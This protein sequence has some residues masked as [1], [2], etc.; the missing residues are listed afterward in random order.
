MIKTG[1]SKLFFFNL[2]TD[3]DS[4][5]LAS[6][7]SW[8]SEFSKHFEE[9][10]VV[11]THIGRT[12]LPGNVRLVSLGGGSALS[13]CIAILKLQK[14]LISIIRIKDTSCVFYHMSAYSAFV[15]GPAIK[16]FKIPQIM[17]YSH[18]KANLISKLAMFWVSK[19]YSTTPNSSPYKSKKLRTGQHGIDPTNFQNF[20]KIQHRKRIISSVGRIVPIKN[21]EKLIESTAGIE[22]LSLIFVGPAPNF[23]YKNFLLNL[24]NESDVDLAILPPVPYEEI[25][26]IY[27]KTSIYYTGTPESI[28]KAAIE[29]AMSGCF[30][31]SNNS[32]L[33]E[34]VGMDKIY[35]QLG[36]LKLNT[37]R[38]EIDF[39]I[40]KLPENEDFLRR[41]ISLIARERN[42]LSI[43]VSKIVDE[44]KY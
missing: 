40:N 1:R 6:G 3:L 28:D 25:N 41:K 43:L 27:K 18:S 24:A 34:V 12:D 20:E 8:I 13:K 30:V 26:R 39:L 23:E 19:V 10:V 5:V 35:E 2:E 11:S 31:V 22:N 37:L 29:A 7:H 21:L 16:L 42:G 15:L 33:K 32:A 38:A 44:L 4:K 9:V 14:I 36:N 17:W